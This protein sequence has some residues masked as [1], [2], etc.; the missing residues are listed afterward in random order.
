MTFLILF[1]LLL[2]FSGEQK[3]E[4]ETIVHDYL[5]EN[6]SVLIEVAKK[7]QDEQ[8]AG[9]EKKTLEAIQEHHQAL[10]Y[11]NGVVAGNPN[12]TINVVE[13][14]DYQCGYCKKSQPVVEKLLEKYPEIR[15]IERPVAVQ[16]EGSIFAARGAI[17]AEKQGKF[18]EFHKALLKETNPLSESLVLEIAKNNGLDLDR[19]KKE[20]EEAAVVIEENHILFQALNAFGTPTFIIAPNPFKETDKA[21]VIPG[22][23]SEELFSES[24]KKIGK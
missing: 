24:L 6:P 7:L 23:L 5:I 4:I 11:G 19:F 18:L 15:L 3:K 9:L 12:G 14:L 13:F 16:G 17:A 1:S 2:Q 22:M 8:K 21:V 20:M 10:F